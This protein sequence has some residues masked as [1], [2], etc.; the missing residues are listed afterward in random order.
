MDLNKETWSNYSYQSLSIIK[1]KYLCLL[2]I[3]LVQKI[4]YAYKLM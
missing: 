4:T 2:S 3:L 1:L